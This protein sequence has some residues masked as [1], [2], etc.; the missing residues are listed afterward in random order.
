M[1]EAVILTDK[2]GTGRERPW[3]VKRIRSELLAVA[4][5]EI[6]ER[7]AAKL[8]DCGTVLAFNVDGDGGK[9]LAGANFCKVRLCPM[10]AW[11]RSLVVYSAVR[12][13]V[14]GMTGKY[15][16]VFLTLTVRNV[17]G[18][19][20]SGEID[21]MMKAWQRLTQRKEWRRAVKGWYRGMEVT[22]NVNWQSA[23]FDT[24]HPH[25]HCLLAVSPRYFK[26]EEYVKQERWVQ[27]WRE[28]LRADYDPVLDVRKVS[29]NTGKDVAEAAK[30]AVKDAELIDPEDWDL[31]VRTVRLL[32]AALDGR[33]LVA[34]G[35]AMK[36]MHQKLELPDE[37]TGD[38]VHINEEQAGGDTVRVEV[39]AWH[40][41]YSQYFLRDVLPPPSRD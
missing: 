18:S 31:T 30:Y 25:F 9:R 28:A 19:Q 34:Y 22:H 1:A 17:P 36:E 6:N 41:G 38:M 33:R 20:L 29:G 35:G 16:F 13:I 14:D 37:E 3:Q 21:R 7:K 4:Y 23:S 32:D 26:G 24:F 40:T 2:T 39:Y 12:Q 27:L 8:R 15:A 5:D 10:C 11:R